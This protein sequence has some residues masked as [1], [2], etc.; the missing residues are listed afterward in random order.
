MWS[1]VS[2]KLAPRV[3][4]KR[5]R[6]EAG[7]YGFRAAYFLAPKML[8]LVATKGADASARTSTRSPTASVAVFFTFLARRIFVVAVSVNVS[9]VPFAFTTVIEPV[10]RAVTT[11]RKAID[12]S[13]LALA[14][15]EVLFE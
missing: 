7:V 8:M 3:H 4:S 11:P 1:K 12:C 5:G 15:L 10:G 2:I 13:A 6:R 9:D 14:W